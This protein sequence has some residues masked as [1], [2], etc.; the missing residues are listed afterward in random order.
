MSK[1]LNIKDTKIL[2]V[3]EMP[4]EKSYVPGILIQ[5]KF[6]QN[7]GYELND[8]VRITPDRKGGINISKI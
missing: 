2:K 7:L 3:R 4:T 6:L 1:K 5:G 8:L